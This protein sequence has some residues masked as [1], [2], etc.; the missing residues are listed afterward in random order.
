MNIVERGAPL[1][2]FGMNFILFAKRGAS[3]LTLEITAKSIYVLK[4]ELHSYRLE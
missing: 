3:L 1:L 2:S 4:E